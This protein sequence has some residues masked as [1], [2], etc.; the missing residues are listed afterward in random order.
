MSVQSVHACDEDDEFT[1][2]FIFLGNAVHDDGGSWQ[3]VSRRTDLAHGV[4][5][6]LAREYGVVDIYAGI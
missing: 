5:D 1:K 4:M 6:S 2:S 3:V